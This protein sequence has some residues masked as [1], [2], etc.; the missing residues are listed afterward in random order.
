MI[1]APNVI[2]ASSNSINATVRKRAFTSS[3][4][5]PRVIIS[6]MVSWSMSLVFSASKVRYLRSSRGRRTGY[7]RG[8]KAS[9][10]NSALPEASPMPGH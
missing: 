4:R 1:P 7:F 6:P 2:A 10:A 8:Q 5:P 3:S 9:N